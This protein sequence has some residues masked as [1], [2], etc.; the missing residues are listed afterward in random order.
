[1][2]EVIIPCHPLT[3]KVLLAH[4]GQEPFILENHDPLF[5]LLSGSRIRPASRRAADG[6]THKAAFLVCDELALHMASHA[7]AIGIKLLRYHKQQLCWY[8]VAHVR[9]RGKGV[10]RTAISDWLLMHGITEDD[11]GLD[12]AYKLWQRFG[13]NFGEKNPRF[14]G[15]LQPKPGGH[16][17]NK[18]RRRANAVLPVRPLI[19][20]HKDIECELALGR[21]LG[22]YGS[23]FRRTPK[24]LPRHARVYVYVEVQ[25]LSARDAARKLG[26]A[27]STAA[28][29]VSRMRYLM[30]R[31][32]TVRHLWV[33]S[34]GLP[35]PA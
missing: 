11:Y 13:W 34:L 5:D 6:L 19:V 24:V 7:H 33:A 12:S 27:H 17:S 31:N 28:H 23:T 16:L 15:H 1:M 20:R 29:A 26:I 8:T 10:A 25:G 22:A 35:V 30:Q 18:T 21:F 32:P 14:V 3:R 9:G 4:Y 2:I